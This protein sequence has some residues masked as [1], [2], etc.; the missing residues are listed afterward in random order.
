MRDGMRSWIS[1]WSEFRVQADQYRE[2]DSERVLVLSHAIA[3]GKASGLELGQM[4]PPSA[5]L[6]HVVGGKVS[7]V[8]I[9]LDRDRAFADLGLEG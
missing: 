4:Q 3:R 1:A 8:V 6:F 7:R 5:N 9:Y 2:L